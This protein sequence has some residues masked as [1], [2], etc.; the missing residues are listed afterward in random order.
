MGRGYLFVDE[1][2]GVLDVGVL[3]CDGQLP[4]GGEDA[5]QEA[6]DTVPASSDQLRRDQGP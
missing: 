5:E 4:L 3:Q 6:D 2:Q 1:P